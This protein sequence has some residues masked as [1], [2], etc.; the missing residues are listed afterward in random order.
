MLVE[1]RRANCRLHCLQ[2]GRCL[3]PETL[4]LT[5]SRY[6][7]PK[8]ASCCLLSPPCQRPSTP[9]SQKAHGHTHCNSRATRRCRSP[10][11][12]TSQSTLITVHQSVDIRF[13]TCWWQLCFIHSTWKSC[14]SSLS[15]H[16]TIPSF[17]W[18]ILPSHFIPFSPQLYSAVPYQIEHLSILSGIRPPDAVLLHSMKATQPAWLH[19][20]YTRG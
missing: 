1:R 16:V 8:S 9:C 14:R 17:P 13:S 3:S 4:L 19:P 2:L 6:S 7:I 10:V 12:G 20:V 18:L 15:D 5:T 11:S